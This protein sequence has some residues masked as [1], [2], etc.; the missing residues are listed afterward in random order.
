MA[1]ETMLMGLWTSFVASLPGLLAAIVTLIIGLIVGKV[2][3][4][5]VKEV[6]DKLKVDE[7]VLEG[8]KNFFKFSTI[9]S[10]I[11]RWWIYLV[12]IQQ[13]TVFL[14]ITVITEFINSVV[15]FLPGLVE[16]SAIIVIGYL[17]AE[18]IKDKIISKKTFYGAL[19]G[20]VV[21]F[22][23]I[24]VAIALALPFV[25]IDTLLINWI[26][27]ILV[28]SVGIG[29]AIAIGLGM[30]DIVAENAKEYMRKARRR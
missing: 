8:E 4:K 22:L 29:M 17:L 23:L 28:G 16:A 18:Y 10:L 26:L 20:K 27:I 2:V 19:V 13:A 15:L 6:L 5:V 1:L 9:L 25:G 7:Y 21:F 3:G 11:A 14:G 12:F 24:Y 30:K